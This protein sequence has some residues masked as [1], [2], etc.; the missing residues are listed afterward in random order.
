MRLNSQE[1]LCN[2]RAEVLYTLQ[3]HK[4]LPVLFFSN[5]PHASFLGSKSL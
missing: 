2:W 3:L 5:D 1:L 4:A